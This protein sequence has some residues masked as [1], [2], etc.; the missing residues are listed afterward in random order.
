MSEKKEKIINIKERDF[1]RIAAFRSKAKNLENK[2]SELEE[3]IA[4][5]Q[6][7]IQE[8]KE[9]S[10][11]LAAEMENLRKRVEKE[12]QEFRSFLQ[13]S[14]AEKLLFF[15]EIFEKVIAEVCSSKD[16]NKNIAEGLIM[17]KNQFGLLLGS[18]G[19]SKIDTKSKMFDPMLHEAI[20]TVETEEKPDGA[21]IEEIRSGYT[22]N[23]RLLRP[24][25][26]KVARGKTNSTGT[27]KN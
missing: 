20:E 3:K 7:E 6:K 2:C 16:I 14:F 8:W 10:A 17:L 24:A 9:R 13:A 15:D 25:Q 4:S 1:R 22:I 11:R 21:I 5:S 18:L 26:V 27:S 19:V 23:G 12:K